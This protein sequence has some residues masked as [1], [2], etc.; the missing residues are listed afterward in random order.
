VVSSRD[1][2]P[3]AVEK[4]VSRLQQLGVLSKGV[5]TTGKDQ[6]S[7]ANFVSPTSTNTH[8][9]QQKPASAMATR[10]TGTLCGWL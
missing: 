1:Q 3:H 6:A 10:K 2:S 9:A 7:G 8:T 4:A 5:D